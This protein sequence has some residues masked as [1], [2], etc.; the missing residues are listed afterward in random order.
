MVLYHGPLLSPTWGQGFHHFLS[1]EAWGNEASS[2]VGQNLSSNNGLQV[3]Y[4]SQPDSIP[5][6]SEQKYF[7]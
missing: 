6:K 7:S 3:S 2:G 5:I 1:Q 4:L